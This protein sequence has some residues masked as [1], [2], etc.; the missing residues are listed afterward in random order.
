MVIYLWP[1]LFY[2]L[3]P[4]K[5]A[6]EKEKGGKINYIDF[7]T[8][9]KKYYDETYRKNNPYADLLAPLGV[10]RAPTNKLSM[11]QHDYNAKMSLKPNVR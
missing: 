5:R 10:M 9:V 3:I 4:P 1:L 8:E 6:K 11:K 7:N 2:I